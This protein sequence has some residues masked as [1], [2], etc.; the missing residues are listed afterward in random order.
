MESKDNKYCGGEWVNKSC[1]KK[2]GKL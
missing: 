1:C 2:M